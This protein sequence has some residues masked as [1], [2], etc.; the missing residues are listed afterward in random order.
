MVD[1]RSFQ[2]YSQLSMEKT[3][4]VRKSCES[5]AINVRKFVKETATSSVNMGKE[6]EYADIGE[7]IHICL[8][9]LAPKATGNRVYAQHKKVVSSLAVLLLAVVNRIIYTMLEPYCLL[10]ARLPRYHHSGQPCR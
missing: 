8:S 2:R 10:P 1:M 6:N 7:S 5:G 4:L 3:A 9:D